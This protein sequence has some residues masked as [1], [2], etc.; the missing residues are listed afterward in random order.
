M[1]AE[2]QSSWGGDNGALREAGTR[3][4]GGD[5][6]SINASLVVCMRA[7]TACF[8]STQQVEQVHADVPES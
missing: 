5:S 6:S 8:S 1:S 4:S 2:L 7:F 3:R